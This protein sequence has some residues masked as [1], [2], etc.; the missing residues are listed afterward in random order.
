MGTQP[1]IVSLATLQLILPGD[2]LMNPEEESNLMHHSM[3]EMGDVT[4]QKQAKMHECGGRAFF[5]SE[6]AAALRRAIASGPRKVQHFEVGQLVYFWSAG[7]FNKV[8][9]HHSATCG[10]NHQFWNG[11]CRVVAVQYTFQYTRV[12]SRSVS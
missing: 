10:P 8:A 2:V 1:F 9:V 6:C 7:H 4:L 3:I 11:P 12:V 5:S